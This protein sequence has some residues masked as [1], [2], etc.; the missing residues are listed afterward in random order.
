MPI[1]SIH[2]NHDDPSGYNSLSPLD[3][4]QSTGLINYFG[5]VSDVDNI[6]LEPILIEKDRKIAI[7][8]MGYIK[9][10]RLY[11][12]FLKGNVLYKRPPDDGWYNILMVHQNRVPREGEYL[13]EDFIDPFFDLVLYGHEHESIKIRHKNFDVIQ[14]GSSIRTSLCD[15]ESYDKYAYIL[16]L[17]KNT[18]LERKILTSVRPIFIESIKITKNDP[19]PEIYSKLEEMLSKSTLSKSNLLPLLRLRIEMADDIDFNKHRIL[20][21]LENKIANPLD[22]VKIVRKSRNAKE[23]KHESIKKSEIEDVYEGILNNVCLKALIQNKVV[24]SVREFVDKDSKESFANLIK[25]TTTLILENIRIEDIVAENIDDAIKNARETLIKKEK[26]DLIGSF[27]AEDQL[28][29]L[30]ISNESP[31]QDEV[32]KSISLPKESSIT[33]PSNSLLESKNTEDHTFLEDMIKRVTDQQILKNIRND[34]IEDRNTKKIK[35]SEGSS[36]DLLVFS[37]YIND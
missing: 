33:Y 35:P 5:K 10:R 25:E 21:L 9:D 1:I 2:G 32:F 7:Y 16:D 23:E 6:V 13:P 11:K 22:A 18:S 19:M 24:D 26:M 31:L 17:S 15:G 29:S 37:K 20:A 28:E 12:T 30:L 36:E 3:V 27:S 8:G 14:C 34:N 4:L